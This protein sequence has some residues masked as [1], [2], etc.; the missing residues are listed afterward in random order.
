[1]RWQSRLRCHLFHEHDSN[2]HHELTSGWVIDMG[3]WAAEPS[4]HFSTYRPE[5]MRH[6]APRK[7]LLARIRTW[8]NQLLRR[9]P[10]GGPA[11]RD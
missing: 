11:S 1:M 10:A 8:W 5:T 4:T 2:C 7:S 9:I 3:L 6:A